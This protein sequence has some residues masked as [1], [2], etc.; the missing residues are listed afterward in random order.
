VP[1]ASGG[2]VTDERRGRGGIA[3]IA[4]RV[5]APGTGIA[6]VAAAAGAADGTVTLAR[7]ETRNRNH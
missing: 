3:Q 4:G 7:I 2:P 6:D 5:R 1:D